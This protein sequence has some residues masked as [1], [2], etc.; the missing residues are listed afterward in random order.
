MCEGAAD[1]LLLVTVHG[2]EGGEDRIDRLL[3]KLTKEYSSANAVGLRLSRSTV[4]RA[5]NNLVSAGPLVPPHCI[6][7]HRRVGPPRWRSSK[8]RSIPYSAVSSKES[9]PGNGRSFSANAPNYRTPSDF[10]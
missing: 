7:R 10:N 1:G 6:P 4:K 5:L 8:Q 9:P 2:V 3:F